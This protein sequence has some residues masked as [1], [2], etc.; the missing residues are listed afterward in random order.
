MK[1]AS[2]NAFIFD[3]DGV[4]VNS[5][6]I[7]KNREQEFLSALMGQRIYE[8]IRDVIPGS[9]VQ[10][11]YKVACSFGFRMDKKAFFRQ[12]NRQA[13]R[14]YTDAEITTGLE[15]LLEK[16]I[17]SNFKIGLV[18]GSRMAWV[19]SVLGKIQNRV[20]F[21]YILALAE[22]DDL[23]SKP[24][25][26]GYLNAMQKLGSV[27]SKTIILEDSMKGIQAA[28]SSGAFTVCLRE[29]IAPDRVSEGAD[30]YVDS[31]QSLIKDF[32]SVIQNI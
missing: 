26:D 16:L 28:K 13:Q 18:T 29:H 21:D 22:R 20:V 4:I 27:P 31:I 15:Q 5:E 10:S 19:K 30:L 23:R 24:Y 3:M 32:D 17:N 6:T 8:S 1:N 12:Y 2:T 9:T 25:P 14:V 11:I 7:W